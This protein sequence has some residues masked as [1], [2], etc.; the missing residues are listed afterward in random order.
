M[1]RGGGEAEADI[2]L[3]PP[4]SRNPNLIDGSFQ[5]GSFR[6]GMTDMLAEYEA[7]N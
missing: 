3:F 1:E 2:G 4:L 6:S 5:E 7:R